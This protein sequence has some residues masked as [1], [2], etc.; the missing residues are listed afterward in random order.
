MSEL[1]NQDFNQNQFTPVDTVSGVDT[2]P[3]KKTGVKVA[4]ISAGAVAVIAGGGA[5]AYNASDFVKNQVK[6]ATNDPQEYYA[7]VIEENAS[8]LAKGVEESY[9]KYLDMA[10]KGQSANAELKYEPSEDAVDLLCDEIFGADVDVES[11]PELKSAYDLLKGIKS[12]SI[13]ADSAAKDGKTQA[14]AY[15]TLNDEKLLTVDAAIDSASFDMFFRIP[16][17][18]E[19]WLGMSLEEEMTSELE[20]NMTLSDV[21]DTYTEILSNPED[22]LSPEETAGFI[23]R[24]AAVFA[25]SIED[26]E[27]EKKEK[28]DIADIT[29]EYTVL[30]AEV[31]GN[32]AYDLA[33]NAL[34][35][36]KK[37]KTL[38]RLVAEEFAVCSEDEYEDTVEGL[39]DSLKTAKEDGEFEGDETVDVEIYVDSLGKIR[40]FSA[41][42][43]DEASTT[44]AYG[45]DGDRIA[46][47][48]TLNTGGDTVEVVLDAEKKSGKYDGEINGTFNIDGEAVELAVEFSD[49]EVVNEEKGYINGDITAVIPEIDPI[50][51]KL[52]SDGKKQEI[53]YNLAIEDTDFGKFTLTM[54][55]DDDAKV[56]MPSKDDATMID[57]ESG[58]FDLESYVSQ[59]EVS[60]WISDLMKKVCGD[61]FTDEEYQTIGE[62][63]AVSF[64]EGYA[65]GSTGV[66]ED[67]DY[68]YEDDFDFEDDYDWDDEELSEN[69]IV[70]EESSEDEIIVDDES[71]EDD[72]TS[73]EDEDVE[74][75]MSEYIVLK[76][77][78]IAL[79]V[80]DE[81]YKAT[82]SGMTYDSLLEGA[83]YAD[84]AGN[85]TYTVSVTANTDEYL[86]N[87]QWLVDDGES[88]NPN[89]FTSIGLVSYDAEELEK[90]VIT[91]DSVKVDG[92]EIAEL[93][94]VEA[95]SY[96]YD[97][98]FMADV[99]DSWDDDSALSQSIGEWT[100]LE[101]TFTVSGL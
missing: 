93:S 80:Y 44:F 13:G 35:T 20:S 87:V 65:S 27:L 101:V 70:E 50:T 28:V 56:D 75:D 5:I 63:A 31:D 67:D 98:E 39:I 64:F 88:T 16:E 43:A 62:Q 37:D 48:F 40:G 6:L 1:N 72:E 78:Q 46:G 54:S 45:S 52:E 58:D 86:E 24:Y 10:E 77:N 90:A 57:I 61:M 25:E 51:V 47:E 34:E 23:T 73:E 22:F 12:I 42:M 9:K 21:M 91:I 3:K 30:T 2:V 81:D 4:A 100:A 19:K 11:D 8:E 32:T 29:V 14:G 99:Y 55:Q 79:Y 96:S 74:F 59:E 60:T 83:V 95:Y 82:A 49:F 71:S 94:G 85:G 26:V 76:K 97:G 15:L 66:V 41:G 38:K 53:I 68:D 84:V 36:A 17:L 33:K 92:E 69:D 18:T 7:W 89:G